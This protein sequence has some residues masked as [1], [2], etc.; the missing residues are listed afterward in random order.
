MLASN[1]DQI[2]FDYLINKNKQK[3]TNAKLKQSSFQCSIHTVET[4]T[5]LRSG[6]LY[7]RKEVRCEQ[8][9]ISTR[10]IDGGQTSPP[11]NKSKN[12]NCG[13]IS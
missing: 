2:S 4:G 9:D 7:P 13:L 3:Q 8:L 10:P 12:T 11:K 1:E 6:F 5:N